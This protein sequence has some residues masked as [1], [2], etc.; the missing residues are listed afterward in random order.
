MNTGR[1]S[2]KR[3]LRLAVCLLL[4]A[5]AFHSI[6]LQEGRS[7]FVRTG[8]DWEA[9]S[10]WERWG[11]AWRHGPAGLW[12]TIGGLR[13]VDGAW[14]LV[15]MGATILLGLLRWRMFLRAQGLE[16]PVARV[17]EISLVAHFFNSVLLGSAGGDL[18]KAY[19]AARETHHLKAESVTTVVVDRM[20]GL[21][22]TLLFAAAMMLP[23]LD[24]LRAHGRLA[25]VSGVV[26][27][28][29]AVALAVVGLSFW[30]GLSRLW[31]GAR[32]W[33]L[34]RL[35]QAAWLERSLLAARV[36]GRRPG[37]L[38]GA[39]GLSVLLNLACV[40]QIHALAR[41]LGHPVPLRPLLVIVPVVIFLSA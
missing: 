3:L 5:V 19:Y 10:T 9:L 13:P 28:G 22:V 6:F 37:L 4:L 12:Q 26:L 32:G 17:A 1:S 29:L 27:A 31:P 35:P 11:V 40:L 41:G 21:C 36:Y 23:N 30:G 24:L 7:A 14:S 20:V 33:L 8:G 15:F 2:A 39:L 38:A 34:S 18:M 25:A 16:L